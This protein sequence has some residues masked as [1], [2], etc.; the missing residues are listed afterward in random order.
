MKAFSQ[1]SRI[2][3]RSGFSKLAKRLFAAAAII[4]SLVVVRG[5]HATNYYWDS[6]GATVGA[7]VTPTGTWGTDPF[8]S[9]N[10]SGTSATTNYTTTTADILKFSAGTDTTGPYTVTMNGTQSAGAVVAQTGNLTLSGGTLVLPWATGSALLTT[11]TAN[12]IVNSTISA[13]NNA[14]ADYLNFSAAAGTTITISGSVT[15]SSSSNSV[16]MQSKGSS[17]TYVETGTININTNLGSDATFKAALQLGGIAGGLGTLNLNGAQTLGT[18]QILYN[19]VARIGTLN[20]GSTVNLSNAVQF[21]QINMY[22]LTGN[23]TGASINV[24]S[25][26]TNTGIT[27]RSGGTL[28]VAGSLTNTGGT[29]LGVISDTVQGATMN[30]LNGGTVSMGAINVVGGSVLTDA[31]SLNATVLTLGE[32]TGN[33]SGKFVMGDA[34]GTGVATLTQITTQ[35]SGIANAIVGGNSAASTLTLNLSSNAAFSGKLGGSGTNENNLAFVKQSAPTLTLSGLNTYTGPTTINAGT[36]KAGV[37]TAGA[38]GAFGNNSAVTLANVA[39]AKLDITGF[40]NSIGSLAGGGST[41]GNVILGSATLTVGGN[42]QTTSYAGVIS[43]ASGSIIKTG[44]GSQIFTG[45]NT[46]TGTTTVSIGTLLISGDGSGATGGMSVSSGATLGGDGTFG[47]NVTVA[48]GGIL[49]AGDRNTTTGILHAAAGKNISLVSS[50]VIEFTLGATATAH[51]TIAMN[52]GTFSLNSS[53]HIS[54]DDLGALEGTNYTGLITG[55]ANPGNTGT[56]I[57]DNS[58]WTGAFSY[59]AGTSSIDFHLITAPEP[60]TWALLL[61]ALAAGS[62]LRRRRNVE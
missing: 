17:G 57:I 45:A 58:G 3:S 16:F 10:S 13:T 61:F 5:L 29:I 2:R 14:T 27:L 56:W 62:I 53:Q 6:N 48:V 9:T 47:G 46:Y 41:G 40:N 54:F 28:N 39:S 23:L 15:C 32:A 4:V 26:V 22:S 21:G 34:T 60:A 49:L 12:L 42:N 38:D 18:T 24:N 37:A 19:D 11:G 43:G 25:A 8:W 20:F 59:N 31:G 50:S 52:G 33:T 1:K 35:G 7:G 55:V 36:L 44:T 51:G 30:I